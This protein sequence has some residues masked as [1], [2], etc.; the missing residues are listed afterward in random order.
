MTFNEPKDSNSLPILCCGPITRSWLYF[1]LEQI[2]GMDV[3]ARIAYSSQ[4]FHSDCHFKERRRISEN[5]ATPGGGGGETPWDRILCRMSHS[6]SLLGKGERGTQGVEDFFHLCM[7]ICEY[8]YMLTVH[9]QLHVSLCETSLHACMQTYF[10][11]SMIM[12]CGYPPPLP[13]SYGS[14]A[15]GLG[16]EHRQGHSKSNISANL[17]SYWIGLRH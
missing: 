5:F 10:Y 13:G 11:P 9:I 12:L 17:K 8:A 6:R 14:S 15:H 1:K 3:I 7:Q 4:T 16:G 2:L